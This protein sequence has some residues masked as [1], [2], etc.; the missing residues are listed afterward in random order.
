MIELSEKPNSQRRLKINSETSED[1]SKILAVKSEKEIS[2]KK[3]TSPFPFEINKSNNSKIHLKNN[4]VLIDYTKSKNQKNSEGEIVNI[5]CEALYY[6]LK[7]NEMLSSARICLLITITFI[8]IFILN[9]SFYMFILISRPIIYS[10]PY[11]CYNIQ[12]NTIGSCTTSNVCFCENT[13]CVTMIYESDLIKESKN[14]YNYKFEKSLNNNIKIEK[15]TR[16]K[17]L[18]GEINNFLIYDL[19]GTKLN[20]QYKLNENFCETYNNIA[21]VTLVYGIS[22]FIF[23][24][25]IGRISD[26]IGKYRLIIIWSILF[27]IV[28]FIYFFVFLS[29]GDDNF[30][31]INRPITDS[32]GNKSTSNSIFYW[33]ILSF[34]SG[35]T[36]LPL[37]NLI[38]NF[39]LELF[40]FKDRLFSINGIISSAGA[41]SY[42]LSIIVLIH[43]KDAKWHYLITFCFTIIFLIFFWVYFSENPRFYSEIRYKGEKKLNLERKKL[44]CFQLLNMKKNDN[45]DNKIFEDK[46]KVEESIRKI[47]KKINK[48]KKI[49]KNNLIS[50]IKK[51]KIYDD[52]F[53]KKEKSIKRNLIEESYKTDSY[54]KKSL[55]TYILVRICF[56]MSLGVFDLS[57]HNSITNEMTDPV[58]KDGFA[59]AFQI[60]INILFNT[61]FGFTSFFINPRYFIFCLITFFSLSL[62]FTEYNSFFFE[63][64]QIG[65][66]GNSKDYFILTT[67][68]TMR[69]IL[70]A[71]ISTANSLFDVSVMSYPPT[72]YRGYVTSIINCSVNFVP[73]ISGMLIYLTDIWGINISGIAFIGLILYLVQINDTNMEILETRDESYI[74]KKKAHMNKRMSRINIVDNNNKKNV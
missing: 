15:K 51:P 49:N 67:N 64:N 47:K 24:L 73:I 66:F 45:P 50:E 55:I 30:F 12:T 71:C 74:S 10:Y 22:G 38:Y 14:V 17:F 37:K 36:T 25:I 28:Q 13:G 18:F 60:I 11:E 34:F 21:Y 9:S 46:K 29:I 23:E 65:Y 63:I 58:Y 61:I 43:L 7:E 56:S 3:S 33:S 72:L 1:L 8:M 52:Y 41:F 16:N 19:T 32:S 2:N 59:I 44:A 54:I 26:Y 40:P 6:Y 20:F 70:S 4:S 68:F 5:S 42:M 48:V 27:L 53:S 31:D 69:S 57:L 39:F 62:F 35:I